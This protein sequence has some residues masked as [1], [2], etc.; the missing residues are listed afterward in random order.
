VDLLPDETLVWQGRPSWRSTMS[1]Y[2]KWIVI[3]II[4][5]VLG[6][7]LGQLLWGTTGAVVIIA[8][9]LIV[10]WLRRL[11]TRYT[12]TD[13]R[14]VINR[15]ILSRH[16]QRAHIDRVQNVQLTQSMFDRL[17]G[18]GTL[19]FDTAGTDDSDFRFIGIA[20]PEELRD[21]IDREYVNRT[22]EMGRPEPV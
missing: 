4:P 6:G 9:A 13:R 11:A 19:D 5:L 15:G 20:D 21:R 12:I 14:I 8:I 22:R 2:A 3:A 7:V 17:F 1:F 16:E 18:V 10:G